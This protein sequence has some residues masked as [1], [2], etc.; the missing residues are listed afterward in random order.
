[1]TQ[2]NRAGEQ[3]DRTQAMRSIDQSL[4][5]M[6]RLMNKPPGESSPLPVIGR[7][8][9]FT[10]ALAC[11]A[12]ASLSASGHLASVKDIAAFL[13]LDQS[14]T[15][16]LLGEVEDAGFIERA[17]DPTDRRR[18]VIRLTPEGAELVEI[19]VGIR[20]AFFGA[21]LAD[22][23]DADM[24]TFARLLADLS[25]RATVTLEQLSCGQVPVELEQAIQTVEREH[26][27]RTSAS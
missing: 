19:V 1:V 20:S 21:L 4:L 25:A 9:N 12:V 22:W 2:T 10:Q 16:R 8:V 27:S 26:R 14:T 13:T 6:R 3:L 15:S 11:E 24:Q 23:S 17:T 7:A 5:R 18:S